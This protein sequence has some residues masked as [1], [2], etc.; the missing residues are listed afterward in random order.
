MSRFYG[1]KSYLISRAHFTAT[2][3]N[4]PFKNSIVW[5]SAGN[6][7]RIFKY[8]RKERKEVKLFKSLILKN[9]NVLTKNVWTFSNHFVFYN[10]T[11]CSI[12]L[13]FENLIFFAQEN[14]F[15]CFWSFL[16]SQLHLAPLESFW[17]FKNILENTWGQSFSFLQ[18]MFQPYPNG[19][20]FSKAKLASK[21]QS[22]KY[23][24]GVFVFQL[25]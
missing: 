21:M 4:S 12:C 5:K 11:L 19:E 1:R 15:L 22:N 16:N 18:I 23:F 7:F 6:I 9:R 20:C 13:R 24:C 25:L 10:S 8:W 14:K 17:S 3:S 2:I